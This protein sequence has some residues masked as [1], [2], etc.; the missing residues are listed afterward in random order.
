MRR[1]DYIELIEG[2]LA[3]E[4]ERADE[5]GV[6]AAVAEQERDDA[7]RHIQRIRIAHEQLHEA[8]YPAKLTAVAPGAE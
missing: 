7:L 8:I 6:A 2:Q 4:R 1:R 3:E 5:N